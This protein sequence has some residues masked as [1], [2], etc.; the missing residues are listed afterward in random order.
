MILKPGNKY[1]FAGALLISLI[2]FS[3]PRTVRGSED[4]YSFEYGFQ[5]R[6]RFIDFDDI[7]DYNKYLD[8]HNQFY[9]FRTCLWGKFNKNN[10]ELKLQLNN[11]FRYYN[12]P[13][14]DNN[15]DELYID[16][17]YIKIDKIL[18]SNWSFRAGRQNFIK[19]NGFFIFDG[20]PLDG[21]R[22]IYFN[23]FILKREFRF[24]N[25]EL[26]AISNP[27]K[28][29]YL[30]VIGDKSK[31]LIEHDEE[32]LGAYIT[33][34]LPFDTVFDA[35]YIYKTE[36]SPH[37]SSS[38][39]FKPK[40]SLHIFGLRT[41]V[42]MDH[43]NQFLCEFGSE[44]GDQDP[45]R[46]IAAWGG[47][48]SLKHSFNTQLKS[49]VKFSAGALSGD[50]PETDKDEGWTPPFSRWPVWSELY[51]YSLIKET[52]VANWSNLWFAN[53]EFVFSPADPVKIRLSYYKMM[54]F[55]AYTMSSSFY[56]GGKNRGDLF[57]IRTDFKLPAGFSGHAVYE[58]HLP[59]NFYDGDDP[60]HFLRFE[61][62]YVFSHKI[63]G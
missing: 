1:F 13:D 3:L 26:F 43:S 36:T 47:Y 23:S 6:A 63:H 31:P 57:Q 28:E 49:S 41:A 10:I 18:N 24:S 60:G 38:S 48:A 20:N 22:S 37:D 7:I 54:A 61:L 34:R 35:T 45:D 29:K 50:D 51:I 17:C 55:E 40:R 2:V 62:N 8:D 19:G 58:Y 59:G 15:F 11:E 4:S 12:E 39:E 33:S 32:A 46:N 42:S 56:G 52:G 9:R 27:A 30:P 44:F 14:R 16:Q 21:S 25:L 5:H 53:A